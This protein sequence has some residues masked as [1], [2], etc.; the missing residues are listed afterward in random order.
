MRPFRTLTDTIEALSRLTDYE[1][2][3]RHGRGYA[4]MSLE[5]IR[6]LLGAIGSPEAAYP[7]LHVTGTKGKG[8]TATLAAAL[9]DRIGGP[10]GLYTSP[11]LESLFERVRVGDLDVS[12]SEW[13]EGLERI[14]PAWEEAAASADD[15]ARPT[16]FD[17]VTAF[18]LDHFRR[19]A[20]RAAVVEVGLGGRLDS[21]NVVSTRV[22][23]VTNVS[24]DH[25]ETLGRSPVAIARE[26][27]GII[28]GP[29]PVVT[30]VPPVT[31]A[32][33][34]I[35]A[36]A[37]AAGARIV[38]LGFDVRVASFS[39][40]SDENGPA[41]ST[42][43]IGLP[44]GRTLK[45]LAL[46]L[47]GRHQAGNAALA[48]AACEAFEG[49]EIPL[50]DR[51]IA[52]TLARVRIAGR[53]EPCGTAPPTLLDGA[54]NPAAALAL[55]SV[56]DDHYPGRPVVLLF[57][58]SGDKDVAGMLKSLRPRVAFAVLTR[59]ASPRAASTDDLRAA[60]RRAGIACDARE[61]PLEALERARAIALERGALLVVTGSFYLV[62]AL[63]SAVLAAA[64]ASAGTT[65]T[66][67]G[68]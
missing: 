15:A 27:S 6:R 11:H 44:S 58:A 7:A 53:A 54:H 26:K 13:I 31:P 48:L 25:A 38:R 59:V 68:S 37:R 28:R 61:E 5:P 47:L 29:I 34:E 3:S 45:D 42:V 67:G 33:G 40:R 43:T 46:G 65:T 57:G 19:R 39:P 64:R 60:S 1:R 51:D 20:V 17:V 2:M 18:A 56:L 12:E 9:L 30:G 63:R 62:G 52:E 50:S 8:S 41:G 14:R 35:E 66:T 16:F 21:T 32:Y 36:A 22:A 4:R 55:R 24:V 10:I 23:L 49:G